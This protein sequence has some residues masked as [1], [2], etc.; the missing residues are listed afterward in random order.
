MA[1]LTGLAALFGLVLWC[2]I[3]FLLRRVFYGYW[4]FFL[5]L[6]D[7]LLY[8]GLISVIIPVNLGVKGLIANITGLTVIGSIYIFGLSLGVY[9]SASLKG[10][11]KTTVWVVIVFL[12]IG[13]L[14]AS[15]SRAPDSSD[16][17]ESE[18]DPANRGATASANYHEPWDGSRYHDEKYNDPRRNL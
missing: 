16:K 3:C 10:S 5:S 18:Y 9:F 2:L 14:S 8:I 7:I 17:E 11:T 12:F 6:F 1:R 15:G 4:P 13:W